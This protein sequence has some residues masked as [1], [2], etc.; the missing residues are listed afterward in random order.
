MISWQ[1]RRMVVCLGCV[2]VFSGCSSQGP[3]VKGTVTL[4]GK[5][6]D[7]V[8]LTFEPIGAVD[9]NATTAIATTD[10]TGNFRIE[11]Q[12]EGQTLNPGKY[13]VTFSRMIDAQGQVPPAKDRPML[14][15]SRQLKESVPA[16]YL[17]KPNS[18][19]A[20]TTEIA[21]GTN[22]LNFDLKSQ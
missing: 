6:L 11:P 3:E 9:V 4:D 14:E 7:N 15:A 8:R 21:A 18:P 17:S 19:P 22:D 1:Q 10:A 13:G 20:E 5:P 2:L 12:A 16:K